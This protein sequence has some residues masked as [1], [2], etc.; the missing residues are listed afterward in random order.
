MFS[1][2]DMETAAKNTTSFARC[3]ISTAEFSKA[4]ETAMPA[5]VKAWEMY[6]QRYRLAGAPYGDTLKGMTR[7]YRETYR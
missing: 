5:I 3:G 2:I 6:E 7:W 4:V 1:M